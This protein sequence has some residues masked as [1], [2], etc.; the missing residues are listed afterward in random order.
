ME[1]RKFGDTNLEVSAISLGC[2]IFG[3][4]WWGHYSQADANRICSFSYDNGITFFDNGDAYGNG[5]AELIFAQWRKDAKID[6]SKIEIG[7]KFGYDF[8]S[9]PG[10]PGSHRERR[11]DFSPHFMRKALEQSLTR[12][13]TD[14]IDLYMAHNIK[15]PQFRDDMFAELGKLKDEGKIKTWGVSLGPA[16]GWY[17]EGIQAMTDHGAKAVQTVFNLFE[18]DPGRAFCQTAVATRAGVL[19]RVHDNSSILKDVVKIDTVIDKDDHRKF[20][21]QA[22]KTYGVKKVELIRPMAQAHGMTIHEFAC[23]WLLQ[24]PGLTSITGT[25]LN[26]KEIQEAIN[27]TNKPNLSSKEL[28]ELAAQ[29]ADDWAMGPEAHPCDHKSSTAEGGTTKSR[30]IAPPVLIA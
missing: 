26:E 16:I 23:K 19:A 28:Q 22:W 17:E 29:Y 4:D 14:Y 18:Q 2:W 27:A 11:Q 9:D 13:D 24:Q 8:Y 25:F 5:R 30:Y 12:L 20:R 15:L 1:R 7:G 10:Q 21:D 3:V 6:R